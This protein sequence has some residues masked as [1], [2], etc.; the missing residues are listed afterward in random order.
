MGTSRRRGDHDAPGD[1]V[2][3]LAGPEHG[4]VDADRDDGHPLGQHAHLGGDVGLGRLGH[5]DHPGQGP[6]HLDL[7]AQEAEPAALGEVLPRVG[8]VAQGQLPVDG[9]GMVQGGEHRPS[10][11]DHAEDAVAQALVVVDQVE[12][13]RGGRPAAAGPAG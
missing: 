1:R 5:G 13:V 4:V 9:D 12:L 7:H 6:G 11:L 8:G 2:D 10:V 3:V